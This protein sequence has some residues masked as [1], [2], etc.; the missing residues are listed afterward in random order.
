MVP[1]QNFIRKLILSSEQYQCVRTINNGW[2]SIVGCPHSFP[3]KEDM[4]QNPK[5]YFN[6][7][8]LCYCVNMLKDLFCFLKKV[9]TLGRYYPKSANSCFV[10]FVSAAS[11]QTVLFYFCFKFVAR[12]LLLRHHEYLPTEHEQK[13]FRDILELHLESMN[14]EM[15]VLMLNK[16]YNPIDR[17]IKVT[18]FELD[19]MP[20][21][22]R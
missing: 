11:Y 5:E 7:K 19:R 8:V 3:C 6:F 10:S 9:P 21:D 1:Y 4:R 18:L 2:N 16:Y 12:E 20:E 22:C 17:G 14:E 15:K 13:F